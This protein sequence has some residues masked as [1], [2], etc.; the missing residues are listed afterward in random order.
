MLVQQIADKERLREQVKPKRFQ[1][2]RTPSS[3]DQIEEHVDT[4][5]EEEDEVFANEITVGAQIILNEPMC[6]FVDLS[7][8]TVTSPSSS[9]SISKNGSLSLHRISETVINL[10]KF[11]FL[12]G[13]VFVSECQ[14]SVI[15]FKLPVDGHLQIR[16][17]NL[18]NCRLLFESQQKQNVILES[19]K[20]CIFHSATQTH[21]VIQ[22]FSDLNLGNDSSS[23][24]SSYQFQNFETLDMDTAALKERYISN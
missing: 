24:S 23:P 13:S 19:C 3:H 9:A 17:H 12:D 11:P 15:I 10:Q 8:C 22:D 21:T 4:G 14:D 2:K 5:P 1:F 18:K 6:S 16:L 7:L 20:N